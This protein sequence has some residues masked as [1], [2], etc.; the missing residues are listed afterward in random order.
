MAEQDAGRLSADKPPTLTVWMHTYLRDVASARV[1]PSTLRTYQSHTEQHIIPALGHHRL[2]HL[3]PQ[4]LTA[5]YRTCS[6]SLSPNSVRRIHALLRRALTIAV[7]WDLI[8]TNPALLV[9]PPSAQHVEIRPYTVA[10]ARR[11]L[12]SASADR[13]EARWVVALTLGVRQGETLG[14]GWEDVDLEHRHLHVRRA[15]QRQADGSLA[16]VATKTVRS[17]RV[18]PMPR[19]VADAL[20]RR[21]VQ[22]EAER[23]AAGDRWNDSD[24]VFTTS[25]GTPIH[26]RN[27]YRSF[28]RL[29]KRARLRRIRLHDL[30]HTTA[31]LLLAQ[32][33][34]AR[35]VMEI[36]GHSQISITMDTYTHVAPELNRAA[37]ERMEELLW[38]EN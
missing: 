14:L 32:G 29:V 36:L 5:F 28:Q 12:A 38:P 7:R 16:L 19:S 34:P 35:V 4:H 21:R 20:D 2:D 25:I 17:N 23:A 37:V 18:L 6:E 27:D 11:L 10:E 9:D 24:L 3:R 26:P 33:V 22:Q 1:R 15:L 8:S 30:R 13:L 31:S